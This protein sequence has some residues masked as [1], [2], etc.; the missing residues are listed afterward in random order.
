MHL[1]MKRDKLD[2]PSDRKGRAMEPLLF[3]R[4]YPTDAFSAS[5]ERVRSRV[6]G[7]SGFQPFLWGV[8]QPRSAVV[9]HRVRLI[10]TVKL[11][12][13]GQEGT[14]ENQMIQRRWSHRVA[15]QSAHYKC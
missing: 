15:I 12:M 4:N 5:F 8:K 6:S 11:E 13:I 1:P 9:F 2:E 14:S 3:L 10:R 7:K